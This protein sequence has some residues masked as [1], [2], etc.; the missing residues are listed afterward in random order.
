MMVEA[1]S[2]NPNL[3]FS[4]CVHSFIWP[5]CSPRKITFAKCQRDMA[6]S[7]RVLA[8]SDNVEGLTKMETFA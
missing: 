7:F 4:K 3:A 5:D 8:V 6:S 2:Q 1:R